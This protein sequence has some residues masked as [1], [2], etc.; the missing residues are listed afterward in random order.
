MAGGFGQVGEVGVHVPPGDARRRVVAAR[1]RVGLAED[2]D[3]VRHPL[4]VSLSG[5]Q[6]HHDQLDAQKHEEVAP[7][8]MDAEHGG[9]PRRLQSRRRWGVW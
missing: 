5:Q 4:L 6:R 3:E 1:G 7:S 2:A 8:G 9:G